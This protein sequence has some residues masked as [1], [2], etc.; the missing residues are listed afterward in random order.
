VTQRLM[1]EFQPLP[2][3]AWQS[4]AG[5]TAR[6]AFIIGFPRSGTTLLGQIL[7]AHPGCATLEE[8]PLL[9][10]AL[11]E[12]IDRPG[13]LARFAALPETA[14]APYREAYWMAV[15]DNGVDPDATFVIDQTALNTI[16]LPVIAKL[17]PE[18]RFVFALRDPR[19]VVLS[20]FRRL[21]AVTPYL[22]EFLGLDSAAWFYD[23]TMRLFGL[24][25]ERLG[26]EIVEVRNEAIARDF[27]REA[28]R[29]CDALDLGWD[30]AVLHFS[31]NRTGAA[32]ATPSAMQ[33][34]RGI[35]TDGLGHW[36]AYARELA[37]V[38]PVLAPWVERYGYGQDS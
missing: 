38:M 3:S 36:K 1:R 4:G 15:R 18:A 10:R 30:D 2:A 6:H 34:A 17:F 16:H 13:G 8:K 33:L 26:R 11:T 14:L 28:R 27:A 20:C 5:G 31:E 35:S 29:L 21:F 23:A 24:Y 19:D 37:P 32:I 22:Y 9:R 12:F 7:A 25:R